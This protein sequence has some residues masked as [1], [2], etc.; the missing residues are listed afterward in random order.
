MY[1]GIAT[2]VFIVLPLFLLMTIG[3]GW[4]T[5]KKA[6]EASNNKWGKVFRVS[7]TLISFLPGFTWLPP[8]TEDL[9]TYKLQLRWGALKK[10][11]SQNVHSNKMYEM[12]GENAPQFILQLAILLKEN[13]KL[14]PQEILILIFKNQAILTSLLSLLKRSVS[15]YLELA[16][17]QKSGQKQN[18]WYV[19]YTNWKNSL[20]VGSLMLLT[21]TPRVL[22]LA[23]YFGSSFP[24]FEG[25]LVHQNDHYK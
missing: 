25:E 1:Y 11:Y 5:L 14:E 6:A 4:S 15:I 12:Y 18:D 17:R 21:V 19:P 22:S 24:M 7:L 16:P 3:D 10:L 9:E 8:A 2:I 13:A 23:V 20:I